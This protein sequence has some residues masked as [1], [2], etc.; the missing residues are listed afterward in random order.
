MTTTLRV[1]LGDRPIGYL[2]N[3]PDDRTIFAFDDDYRADPKRPILSLSFHNDDGTLRDDGPPVGRLA[4]PF[5]SNLLPEGGLRSLAARHLKVS[6]DRDFPLL[7]HL[8]S[9]LL[10]A[11]RLDPTDAID[12]NPT[13]ESLSF[14]LPGVQLKLSTL[15][16]ESD[17]L[18]I[19]ANGHGAEWIVKVA[20]GKLPGLVENEYSML[21]FARMVGIDVPDLRL[22][23]PTTINGLPR[24]FDAKGPALAIRRFDR[25]EDGT[26][27]HI[28]DFNQVFGQF[29]HDKYDNHTQS[30]IARIL[31]V[32]AGQSEVRRFIERA[33]F[34]AAISNGD[35]HLKNWSLIYP[36]GAPPEL[37]PAYDYVSTLPYDV[38]HDLG[39]SFGGDKTRDVLK[40]D[41]LRRFAR[42]A[43]LPYPFVRRT[44]RSMAERIRE[45]WPRFEGPLFPEHHALLTAHL[46]DIVDGIAR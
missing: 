9:N 16:E 18:T 11:V 15:L 21:E 1:S 42:S 30:D 36:A 25:R 34:T 41:R 33:I 28:E 37:A 14:A 27:V 40:D 31:N 22:V 29:P 43:D 26:R 4:P 20:S 38:D 3:L 10:G 2:T 32:R 5:F 8:G 44:A 46:A 19:P 17:A 13:G 39:L 24:E 6:P 35:M 45:T 23:D 12:V 7:Q